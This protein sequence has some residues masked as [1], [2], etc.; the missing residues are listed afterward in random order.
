M[1][2]VCTAAAPVVL[3]AIADIID[4]SLRVGDA[5]G[6]F[7]GGVKDFRVFSV[8]VGRAVNLPVEGRD[9]GTVLSVMP[10]ESSFELNNDC[11]ERTDEKG[12]ATIVIGSLNCVS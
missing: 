10:N 6:R 11:S 2:I 9:A 4:A 7:V 3:L 1:F 8:Y 12:N 5:V